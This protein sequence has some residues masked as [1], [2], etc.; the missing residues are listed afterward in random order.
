VVHPLVDGLLVTPIAPHVLTNRPLVVPG[1]GV[2]A[3]QAAPTRGLPQIQ[4]C[5]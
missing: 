3:V 1:R 2:I 5:S 4:T